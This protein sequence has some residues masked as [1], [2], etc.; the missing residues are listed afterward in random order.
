MSSPGLPR[1]HLL[2]ASPELLESLALTIQID[3]TPPAP[4]W[5]G[6]TYEVY[7]GRGWFTRG[8]R[9]ENY[10]A[11]ERAADLSAPF[12]RTV[13]QTVRDENSSGLVYASGI[14]VTVD[15][16]YQVAWRDS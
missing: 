8:F 2:G 1:S 6:S 7:S 3:E 9:L 5:L 15:H 11:N 12:Y 10:S 14:I 4:Y 16:D 13:H